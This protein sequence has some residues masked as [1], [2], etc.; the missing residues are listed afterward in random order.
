MSTSE[1][2]RLTIFAAAGN[3]DRVEQMLMLENADVN[4]GDED[5]F[6]ALM[7]AARAGNLNMVHKLFKLAQ[8]VLN[9]NATDT[10]GKTALDYAIEA[11]QTDIVEFMIQDPSLLPFARGFLPA[12]LRGDAD[13]VRALLESSDEHSR[14]DVNARDSRSAPAL[15]CAIKAGNKSVITVL[16]DQPSLMINARD[17][18][19]RTALDAAHHRGD[20][21]VALILTQNGARIGDAVEEADED[22]PMRCLRAR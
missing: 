1:K 21:E 9:L 7:A 8:P 10:Q 3:V 13:V 4:E 2:G 6:T 20:E 19:G 16:L 11:E 5:G 12:I 17:R 18:Y 22:K 14:A 15:H